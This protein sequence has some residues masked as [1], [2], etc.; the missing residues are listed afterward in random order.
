MKI[1]ENSITY[2]EYLQSN[3]T[4]SPKEKRN[5]YEQ[6]ISSPEWKETRKKIL[7]RDKNECRTCPSKE[8]LE[9]HH[10]HYKNLGNEDLD[11]LTCLCHTCHEAITTR[12]RR[13]RYGAR[14]IKLV[15]E[16]PSHKRGHTV[17]PKTDVRKF[18]KPESTLF[19]GSPRRT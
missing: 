10:R 13:E 4:I 12:I 2:R 19:K 6:H 5:R 8:R 1:T 7:E 11:D 9:V 15:A 18:L 17:Q 16:K 3:D 14:R